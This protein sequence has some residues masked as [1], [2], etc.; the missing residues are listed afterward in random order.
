MTQ[1]L[2]PFLSLALCLVAIE[3]KA[4]AVVIKS[5]T[6]ALPVGF[7]VADGAAIE[8]SAGE[9]ITIVLQSGASRTIAGPFASTIVADGAESGATAAIAELLRS[10]GQGVSLLGAV[11]NGGQVDQDQPVVNL[12]LGETACLDPAVRPVMAIPPRSQPQQLLLAGPA[13]IEISW[14]A[15]TSQMSW[16]T[17]LPLKDGASYNVTLDGL[18]LG[19]VAIRLIADADAAIGIRAKARIEAGCLTDALKLL[20]EAG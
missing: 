17:A 16:P 5:D 9:S 7:L 13:K 3:S 19:S 15:S 4:D 10:R 8:L 18:E 20:E 14:P 6:P 11:R 2:A 1:I 12:L